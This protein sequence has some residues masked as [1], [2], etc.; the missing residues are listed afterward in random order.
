MLS[1]EQCGQ[2]VKALQKTQFV[3]LLRAWA[4]HY[5]ASG[6][7]GEPA[8]YPTDAQDTLSSVLEAEVCL[9]EMM[10]LRHCCLNGCPVTVLEVG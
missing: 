4:P 5:H 1:A 6:R 8:E 7:P 9:V 10:Q 2:L 3:A